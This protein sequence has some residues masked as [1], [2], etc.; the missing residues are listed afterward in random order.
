MSVEVQ[1]IK[2]HYNRI[3]FMYIY[4]M[5]GAGG[6]GFIYLFSKD[7][8]TTLTGIPIGEPLMSGVAACSYVAFGVLSLLGLRSPLTFVPVLL[9][10]LV[11]KL[12]WFVA[13]ILP[14][15]FAGNLPSYA[16]MMCAI[17]ATYVIG[18]LLAIP[19]HY[20]LAREQAKVSN[21]PVARG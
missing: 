8:F 3:K 9:L 10:Q 2:V 5:L 20:L 1:T 16:I 12:V 17:F 7:T 13:I 4:T 19:F 14:L 18:D 15:V 21:V 11:Y 6:L